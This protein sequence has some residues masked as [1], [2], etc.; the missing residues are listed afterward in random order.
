MSQYVVVTT[1]PPSRP[2]YLRWGSSE[3]R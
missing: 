1:M 2:F 3:S